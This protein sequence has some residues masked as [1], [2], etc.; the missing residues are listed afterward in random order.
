[1]N[2]IAFDTSRAYTICC[3]GCNGSL[4]SQKERKECQ[5]V[6]L[7]KTGTDIVAVEDTSEHTSTGIQMSRH[8]SASH[9]LHIVVT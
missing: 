4:R 1:M 2:A 7:L 5:T 9:G 3:G 8:T 6:E